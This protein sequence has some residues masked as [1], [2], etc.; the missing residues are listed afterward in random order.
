LLDASTLP[1]TT[2]ARVKL[3]NIMTV[4]TD[5]SY[6]AVATNAAWQKKKSFLDKAS[7]KTKK[8]GLGAKLALAEKSWKAIPWA[9]LDA[10][11]KTAGT[12]ATAAKLLDNAKD[13]LLKVKTAINFLDDAKDAATTTKNLKSLTKTSSLAANNIAN[14]L[15]SAIKRLE[16]IKVTDF[17]DLVRK[18]QSESTITLTNIRVQDGTDTVMTGGSAT[19]DR[20]VLKVSNVVWKKGTANDING[21]KVIVRGD[22]V[23]SSQHAEGI[24]KLFQNDMKIDS[25]AGNTAN[26]K[27]S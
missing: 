17:E 3:E 25:A 2:E 5:K 22:M 4:P 15:A 23:G 1:G 24:S 16:T 20:K 8:T 11:K 18:V 7:S 10:S 14:A 19:W 13:A 12:P 9:D 27:S 6:P 21:K 26:F